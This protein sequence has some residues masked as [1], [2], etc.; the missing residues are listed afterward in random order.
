MP[1]SG[2][3]NLLS[4]P[5]PAISLVTALVNETQRRRAKANRVM[6]LFIILQ[7][8]LYYMLGY[9]NEQAVIKSSQQTH[10]FVRIKND[11]H[12][13]LGGSRVCLLYQKRVT[14]FSI[15]SY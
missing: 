6:H 2:S 7:R 15:K 9:E 14:T 8:E 1:F 13:I 10:K 11:M 12:N 4:A 3:S 5:L